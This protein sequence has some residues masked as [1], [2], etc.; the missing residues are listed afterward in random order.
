M[1]PA[2][3]CGR[4]AAAG[5][6]CG[7]FAV[8]LALSFA[9]APAAGQVEETPVLLDSEGQPAVLQARY[10][11]GSRRLLL[12][13]PE[14]LPLE[15]EHRASE[16]VV[17]SPRP[18]DAEALGE[19]APRLV[20]WV[21]A[22][23]WGYDSILLE[24]A[25]GNGSTV[26]RHP[27][28]VA[29]AFAD[30]PATGT[31]PPPPADL[32][33]ED[34]VI[35]PGAAPPLPNDAEIRRQLLLARADLL[36]G[37]PGAAEARTQDLLR[38]YPDRRDVLDAAAD[39]AAQA[40]DWAEAGLLYDRLRRAAPGNVG[41]LRAAREARRLYGN[42][43]A[44]SGFVQEVEGADRQHGAEME[45]R[46]QPRPDWTLLARARW[47][48]LEGD[49]I[50]QPDGQ[51]QSYSGNRAEGSIEAA[52]RHSTD[53]TFAGSLLV[54]PRGLGVGARILYGPPND[55]LTVAGVLNEPDMVYVESI[56][57]QG[58][59]DR[60][61]IAYLRSVRPDLTLQASAGYTAYSLADDPDLARSAGI[62][63]E[64]DYVVA[65]ELFADGPSLVA[66]YRF[67]G[68]WVLENQE[69]VSAQGTSFNPLPIVS[70]EVST[71]SAGVFG[72]ISAN[73]DYALQVG[74]SYDRLNGHGP[75]GALR[76]RYQ[77]T[78]RLE[79]F[80][81]ASYGL[82]TGRGDDATVMRAG[83]GMAV[84]F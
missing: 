51:V 30:A 80:G 40:G 36:E 55:R 7:G 19:L 25:P 79:F 60:L 75:D 34:T 74:Y 50:L 32:P 47:R 3:P 10:D 84:N 49:N 54:N 12:V 8:V 1:K 46:V 21:E 68:E 26:A 38:L 57:S 43:L 65:Q 11:A 78:D 44:L 59:R 71:L 69:R 20:P 61:S 58:S 9:A 5:L 16:I 18:I 37:D 33:A 13:W 2:Q 35:L 63:A 31:A 15:V 22:V 77:P 81:D 39:A 72:W 62:G 23:S 82:S 52:W 70:R 76:L 41:Y 67:E 4:R 56:A 66:T 83:L 24:L 29:L 45:L 42:R 6:L 53:W 28:G 17:R 27:D 48:H 64:L 73:T 14:P